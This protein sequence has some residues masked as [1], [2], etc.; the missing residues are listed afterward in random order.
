DAV[1][2][3]TVNAETSR[4]FEPWGAGLT[5]QSGHSASAF[6]LVFFREKNVRTTNSRLTIGGHDFSFPKDPSISAKYRFQAAYSFNVFVAT[7][8]YG[9]ARVTT[10]DNTITL[11]SGQPLKL[12]SH[13]KHGAV[14]RT[15]AVSG[16]KV[17]TINVDS[18]GQLRSYEQANGDH[19]FG[20]R[21]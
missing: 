17:V 16:G 19:S 4:D 5:N 7:I 14:Y 2:E 8:P 9:Q 1:V 10:D 13:S 18:R 12:E 3:W 20:V 6:F 21:F 15:E 11:P